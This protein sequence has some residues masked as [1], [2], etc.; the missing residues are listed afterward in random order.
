LKLERTSTVSIGDERKREEHDGDQ[1]W[2]EEGETLF[3]FGY[4]EKHCICRE[5]TTIFFYNILF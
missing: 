3:F 2:E 5:R 4:K 1:R